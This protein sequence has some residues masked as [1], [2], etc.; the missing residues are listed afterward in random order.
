V[1]AIVLVL[2]GA[3][4]GGLWMLRS[5]KTPSPPVANADTTHA[6][7][8][9]PAP[10]TDSAKAARPESAATTAAA[11]PAGTQTAATPPAGTPAVP[12]QPA[13]PP[14]AQTA[15]APRPPSRRERAAKH[16]TPE[17][18]APPAAAQR[19]VTAAGAP[20]CEAGLVSIANPNHACWDTRPA[21]LA[22]PMVGVPASCGAGALPALTLNVHVSPT[23]DV[24]Q[25]VAAARGSPCRAFQLA[26]VAQVQDFRFTP[27]KK[28]GQNV[29][30]WTQL[31]I[32]PV[33]Q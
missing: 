13:A 5:Q 8:P 1:T 24:L 33:H 21:P 9:R 11:P 32:R 22:Q 26:A 28:G 10:G 18:K 16:E 7:T 2:V 17:R 15:A 12:G 29:G 30:A 20:D 27:A 6:A 4:A 25:A 3:G 31:V 19:A 14:P 23:G